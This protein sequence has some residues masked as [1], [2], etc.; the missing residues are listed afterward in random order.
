MT[1]SWTSGAE[2]LETPIPLVDLDRMER[3]LDRMAGYASRH[4]L[5]LEARGRRPHDRSVG[6]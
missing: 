2:A 6:V 5:A 3:N 4:G 1:A